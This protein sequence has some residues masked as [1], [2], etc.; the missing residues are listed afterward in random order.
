MGCSQDDPLKQSMQS[1]LMA[2]TQQ[3]DIANLDAKVCLRHYSYDG[4]IW[5]LF[6]SLPLSFSPLCSFMLWYRFM[7][8]WSRLMG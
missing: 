8:L 2:N 5:L 1:F 7:K 6:P 4:F 3:Q